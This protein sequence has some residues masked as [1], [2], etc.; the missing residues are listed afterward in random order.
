[1]IGP[2]EN[3]LFPA[4]LAANGNQGADAETLGPCN[5]EHSPQEA[6]ALFLAVSAIDA[7]GEQLERYGLATNDP[8]PGTVDAADLLDAAAHCLM[9]SAEL[10]DAT[11]GAHEADA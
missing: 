3:P 5:A 9:S 7:A 2:N 11:K 1:M 6:Q 4:S 10:S 8:A